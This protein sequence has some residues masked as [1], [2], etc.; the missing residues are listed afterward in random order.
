MAADSGKSSSSR[1]FPKLYGN[2]APPSD[3]EV[4]SISQASH[5]IT[6]V[7]IPVMFEIPDFATTT[8]PLKALCHCLIRHRLLFLW[9]SN[10]VFGELLL[11]S[12]KRF[13]YEK[14]GFKNST[15]QQSPADIIL[16]YQDTIDE[17]LS[18]VQREID[19]A[20]S[21]ARSHP[22]FSNRYEPYWVVAPEACAVMSKSSDQIGQY[23]G[24]ALRD[25]IPAYVET[26]VVRKTGSLSLP[27]VT[28]PQMSP[29]WK[30]DPLVRWSYPLK[31]QQTINRL[32]RMV[33]AEQGAICP[34]TGFH[35]D[36]VGFRYREDFSEIDWLGKSYSFTLPQ[37]KC[38]RLLY[39]EWYIS[40]D[41]VHCRQF[42]TA[43][44]SRASH[45]RLS[46][47][48]RSENHLPH[49]FWRAG[50]IKRTG[51]GKYSLNPPRP[52]SSD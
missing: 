47:I 32:H 36:V 43:L 46:H 34:Q 28:E 31:L 20:V 14:L 25:P 29:D 3:D 27:A 37:A 23:V 12:S 15:P 30:S 13:L 21:K 48:F 49:P 11:Q 2:F 18:N 16:Q 19:K 22:S 10:P 17:W 44:D 41:G 5:V 9:F 45:F 4:N 8:L 52:A 33:L 6:S 39:K 7:S 51:R 35:C 1:Q 50:H 24:A 42:T 38:I 40:G 26:Q